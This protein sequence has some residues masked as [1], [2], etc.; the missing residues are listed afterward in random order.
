MPKRIT[1]RER[2]ISFAMNATAEQIQDMI[3]TLKAIANSR[4]PKVAKTRKKAGT[5]DDV[6]G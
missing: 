1:D 4:F 2:I 6:E 5:H 3:D